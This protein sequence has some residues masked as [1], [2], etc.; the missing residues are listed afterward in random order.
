MKINVINSNHLDKNIN[1]ENH[2]VDIFKSE[3]KNINSQRDDIMNVLEPKNILNE[4]NNKKNNKKIR[5]E[6][7]INY[8]NKTVSN[9]I[10]NIQN[11]RLYKFKKNFCKFSKLIIKILFIFSFIINIILIFFCCLDLF[12]KK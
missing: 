1:I 11:N 8:H 5:S 12:Y 7:P 2:S 4:N 10:Y 6:K 3:E 9:F